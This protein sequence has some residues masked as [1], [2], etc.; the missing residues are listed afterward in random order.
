VLPYTDERVVVRE[1][2]R[3]LRP[4]AVWELSVHGVGYYLR[5]LLGSTFK[6]RVYAARTLLNTIVYRA[7]GRRWLGDTIYQSARRLRRDL[8]RQGLHVTHITPSPTFAGLPYFIYLRVE[9][10]AKPPAARG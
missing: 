6:Q 10:T 2:A 3:V 9:K 1:V 4:G 7:T 5:G 8:E